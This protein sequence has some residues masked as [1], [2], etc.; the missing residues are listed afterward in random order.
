LSPSV[1]VSMS[2]EPGA[3]VP[4]AGILRGGR[5]ATGGS[6]SIPFFELRNKITPLSCD[7]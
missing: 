4:H 1:N 2:E 5:R 7:T 6:T 3:V